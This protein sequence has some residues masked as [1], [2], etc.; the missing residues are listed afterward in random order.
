MMVNK[1]LLLASP[2]DVESKWRNRMLIARAFLMYQE[3]FPLE[4][5]RDNV[6]ILA[7]VTLSYKCLEGGLGERG[8]G[9]GVGRVPGSNS[10]SRGRS[11]QQ[12]KHSAARGWV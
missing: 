1:A 9:R 4:N 6:S 7:V 10:P 5:L 8:V 12:G 2:K 11:R 3:F